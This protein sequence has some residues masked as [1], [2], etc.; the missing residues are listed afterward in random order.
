LKLTVS[1][2][3]VTCLD[4]RH[5]QKPCCSVCHQRSHWSRRYSGQ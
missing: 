1:A 4:P 2:R 5:R 3:R